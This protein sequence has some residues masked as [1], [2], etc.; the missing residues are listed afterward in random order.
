MSMLEIDDVEIAWPEGGGVRLTISAIRRPR[1]LQ[2]HSHWQ[3]Q[4]QKQESELRSYGPL[5]DALEQYLS[6]LRVVRK[7][8]V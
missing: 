2:G 3:G 5:V 8:P 4:K 1:D 6:E 7:M